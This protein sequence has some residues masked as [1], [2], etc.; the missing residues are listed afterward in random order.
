MLFKKNYDRGSEAKQVLA[1]QFKIG[2]IEAASGWSIDLEDAV[3]LA[4][5]AERFL[6]HRHISYLEF[7][8]GLSTRIVSQYLEGSFQSYSMVSLEGD[9]KYFMEA[10]DWV[11][12]K[13]FSRGRVE[14]KHVPY[15]NESGVFAEEIVC[16]VLNA[17]P[18]DLVFVDAPPDTNALD[19]RLKTVEF[20]LPLLRRK[21]IVV[22]HDAKRADELYAFAS[23]RRK[24]LDSSFYET[25]KGIAV[26][27]FPDGA[28]Q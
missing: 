28:A 4:S 17:G 25:P 23:L 18:P 22:I 2:S 20:F 14:I 15:D 6:Q 21:S 19:V 9:E 12:S 10:R 3:V 7:G 8:F 11:E 13:S 16:D 5:E 26:L 1:K 24:F 27:R